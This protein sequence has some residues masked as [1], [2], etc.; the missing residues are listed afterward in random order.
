MGY[1][2]SRYKSVA[3]ANRVAIDL[4]DSHNTTYIF[5]TGWQIHRVA[6]NYT[7]CMNVVGGSSNGHE[8]GDWD[9]N[10]GGNYVEFLYATTQAPPYYYIQFSAKGKALST[11]G[12]TV[13]VYQPDGSEADGAGYKWANEYYV[14]GDGDYRKFY[15]KSDN[16]YYLVK[17]ADGTLSVTGTQASATLWRYLANGIRYDIVDANATSQALT[18]NE[19]TST[20]GIASNGT[21]ASTPRAPSY[22]ESTSIS[23]SLAT[24]RKPSSAMAQRWKWQT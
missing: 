5:P 17:N 22:P 24:A 11:D 14:H 8:L 23:P 13:T 9:L 21:H 12:L 2:G 3:E 1:S 7:S 10:D 19:T 4:K 20:L 6:N 18:Y 15:L 16:G